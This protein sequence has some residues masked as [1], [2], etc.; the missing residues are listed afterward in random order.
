[1]KI[2]Y[3]L[4]NIFLN[5]CAVNNNFMNTRIDLIAQHITSFLES[6]EN[7]DHRAMAKTSSILLH[8]SM[9][10][11]KYYINEDVPNYIS[12]LNQ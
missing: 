6:L 5:N 1:M 4:M 7:L 11:S 3:H 9:P 10:I 2:A 12:S 8:A